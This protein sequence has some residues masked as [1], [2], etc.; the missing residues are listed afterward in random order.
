MLEEHQITI[1]EVIRTNLK[2]NHHPSTS[3]S[4]HFAPFFRFCFHPAVFNP[5]PQPPPIPR[6]NCSY[7]LLFLCFTASLS[8]S[9]FPLTLSHPLSLSSLSLFCSLSTYFFSSASSHPLC[10]LF[11][12]CDAALSPVLT[13]PCAFIIN[14]A[15]PVFHPLLSLCSLSKSYLDPLDLP[16]FCFFFMIL[17]IEDFMPDNSS[18]VILW[19][20]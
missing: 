2:C 13:L 17:D 3:S 20:L 10:L 19:L 9:L 18:S 4:H 8:L 15:S 6:H 7:Y 14:F 11:S 5:P 1:I 12:F 16:V